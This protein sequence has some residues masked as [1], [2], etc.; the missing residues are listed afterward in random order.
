MKDI[1]ELIKNTEKYKNALIQKRLDS[2]KNTVVYATIE[3]KPRLLKWFAPGLKQNM[4]TEFTILRKGSSKLKMPAV[5]EKDVENSVL[6][7]GYIIG[8]N[9]CELIND[10]DVPFEQKQ[11]MITLLSAWFASFHDHFRSEEGF[12]IRGDPSLRN[13]IYKDWVWGVD[14]EESRPGKPIEDIA[15]MCAS[16]LSTDPMFTDEKFQLCRIFID[17]YRKLV[18]WQLDNISEAIAYALLE[19]IQWRP[20]DEEVLRKNAKHI[21]KHGLGETGHNL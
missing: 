3:G 12:R 20:K 1:E 5:L 13:F 16:I 9:L 21:R 18:T 2:K 4:E 17:S 8:E 11:K 6:I 15:G 19:R 7:L 14:F 10:T